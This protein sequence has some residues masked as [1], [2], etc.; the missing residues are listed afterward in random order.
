MRFASIALLLFAGS[1][2][3]LDPAAV[4]VV[5]NAAVPASQGVA[6]HYLKARAVPAANLLMLDLPAGEAISRADYDAKLAKP[7][8]EFLKGKPAVTCVLA[9][10]G[11]PLRIEQSVP[12]AAEAAELAEALPKWE[13]AKAELAEAT[14]ATP[15][16]AAKLA[17][18]AAAERKWGRRVHL[19]RKAETEAAV[20]SELMLLMHGDYPLGGFQPNPLHMGFKL[21]AGKKLPRTLMACRLDGPTEAVARRLVDAAVAVEKAGGLKGKAYIDARGLAFDA[22]APGESGTGYEGYDESFR[23][24]AAILKEAKFDVVLDDKPAV[25]ADGSR[26]D[27][28]IYAGWYS[29][30]KFVHPCDFNPGAVAWHLASY[31]L[32]TMRGKN[33]LWVP[34]LLKAGA[35]VTLG[36]VHEPYTVGF[37]KPAEFFGLLATGE[38]TVAEC[39]AKTVPLTSW[40]GVLVGDPLYNPFR[41]Q[42]RL[43]IADVKLS[44][45][46]LPYPLQ[47]K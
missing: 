26:P 31:E 9:V 23:E 17:P 30:G 15:K 14:K 36:P 46:G 10:H 40:M 4:V 38:L 16:D 13:A 25:F 5:G 7:L 27:A 18:L 45:V 21:P 47:E 28:A 35:A 12:T 19:L 6:D 33:T 29:A 1:A 11:V 34:N 39:Y 37:P 2:P 20:D 24:T 8:R 3:A 41:G 22:K 44:P 43:T 32:G 42:K